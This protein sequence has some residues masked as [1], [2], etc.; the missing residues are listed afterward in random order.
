MVSTKETILVIFIITAIIILGGI[1]TGYILSPHQNEP[2]FEPEEIKDTPVWN[3]SG[4]DGGGHNY[5][6]S[7]T[8]VRCELL[9][10]LSDTLNND[11]GRAICDFDNENYTIENYHAGVGAG[12]SG[13]IGYSGGDDFPATR[14]Y[15]QDLIGGSSGGSHHLPIYYLPI[16]YEA[17]GGG[18]PG[19]YR[20]INSDHWCNRGRIFYPSQIQFPCDYYVGYLNGDYP[21]RGVYL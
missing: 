7:A 14:V 19:N 16:Y 11:G 2:T 10:G 8:G 12:G 18:V 13:P 20:E 4:N 9:V 3:I 17:K 21:L 15:E 6:W 1:I 5:N